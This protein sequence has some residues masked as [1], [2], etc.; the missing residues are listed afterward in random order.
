MSLISGKNL[1]SPFTNKVHLMTILAVSLSFGFYRLS[2]GGVSLAPKSGA[3]KP[4]TD[5]RGA[6]PARRSSA[7]DALIVPQS[8][9]AAAPVR[10]DAPARAAEK[11]APPPPAR[12]DDPFSGLLNASRGNSIQQTK[13]AAPARP[14]G[15]SLE[16]IEKTLGLR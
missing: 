6:P 2:G 14:A 12:A 4:I 15:N 5:S 3:Q 9:L 1:L 13:P 8:D 16:D 10:G 7:M 11:P